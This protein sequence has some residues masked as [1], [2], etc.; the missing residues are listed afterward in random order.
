VGSTVWF[1]SSQEGVLVE[2]EADWDR[3]RRVEAFQQP[4]R[5]LGWGLVGVSALPVLA[6][7]VML[8]EPETRIPGVALLGASVFV[9][10]TGW[11]TALGPARLRTLRER[12]PR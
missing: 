1:R 3:V 10:W 8:G 2:L 9:N 11:R 7:L 5:G 4:R 12:P 6:G